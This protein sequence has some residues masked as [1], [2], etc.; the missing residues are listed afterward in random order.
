MTATS[1]AIGVG[2]PAA[3]N[4]SRFVTEI[5]R[6]LLVGIVSVSTP[7]TEPMTTLAVAPSGVVIGVWSGERLSTFATVAHVRGTRTGHWMTYDPGTTLPKTTGLRLLASTVALARMIAQARTLP[8]IAD[9]LN[10]AGVIDRFRIWAAPTELRGM[11][12]AA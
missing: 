9:G 8:P 6:P 11:L 5:L 12:M 2:C 1:N 4:V 3:L 10:L 7:L